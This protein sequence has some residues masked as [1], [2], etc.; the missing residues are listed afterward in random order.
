M[1]VYIYM[2]KHTLFMGPNCLA[3][4]CQAAYIGV[5]SVLSPVALLFFTVWTHRAPSAFHRNPKAQQTTNNHNSDPEKPLTWNNPHCCAYTCSR[6]SP[7]LLYS[8]SMSASWH[9]FWLTP[10]LA[11][12]SGFNL[13]YVFPAYL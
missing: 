2:Y 11:A 3:L 8:C 9:L 7:A 12:F 4:C 10:G 5:A 13:R 6:Q 1:Y